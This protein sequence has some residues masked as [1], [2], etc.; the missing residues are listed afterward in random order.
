[1]TYS[2]PQASPNYLPDMS[3]C[4]PWNFSKVFQHFWNWWKQ[5]E[6]G[7]IASTA[8]ASGPILKCWAS[9]QR[10]IWGGA[11]FRGIQFC[12]CQ[13]YKRL[14]VQ[15]FSEIWKDWGSRAFAGWGLLENSKLF[16]STSRWAFALGKRRMQ[17][18]SKQN[19]SLK[20]IQWPK[21][22]Y[23]IKPPSPLQTP[24]KTVA[25][26]KQHP[27]YPLWPILQLSTLEKSNCY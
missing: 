25:N 2:P 14:F 20:K 12:Q 18:F 16:L 19:F 7:H 26:L 13:S 6:T 1:M 3:M 9:E 23:Q 10:P 27:G 15:R 11:I 21:L 4:P 5:D 22:K 24:P 8:L 17:P